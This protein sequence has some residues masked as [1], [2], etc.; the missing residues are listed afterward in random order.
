MEREPI[1]PNTLV[2]QIVNRKATLFSVLKIDL[3]AEK[4]CGVLGKCIGQ[5]HNIAKKY[6]K[7][8]KIPAQTLKQSKEGIEEGMVDRGRVGEEIGGEDWWK[9]SV[10]QK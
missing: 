8:K 3:P 7:K 5:W 4:V 1:K 2:K 6:W 9:D 10:I